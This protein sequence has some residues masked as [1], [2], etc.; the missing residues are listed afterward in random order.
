LSDLLFSLNIVLPIL[1][2][3]LTG[4]AFSRLK[5]A[6]PTFIDAANKLSFNVFLPVLLF[7]SIIISDFQMVFDGKLLVF[8]LISVAVL[9]VLLIITVPLIIR[10][11]RKSAIIQGLFRSNFIIFGVPICRG[12]AGDEGA[13]VAA[14]VSAFL[15]PLYNILMVI[16][17]DYY[18]KDGIKRGAWYYLVRV[19]K[20]PLVIAGLAALLYI[21]VSLLIPFTLPSAVGQYLNY[22]GGL[23]T[24]FALILL[25]AD[26]NGKNAHKNLKTVALVTFLKT[27]AIPFVALAVAV[28]LG[29]QGVQLAV[30]LTVFGAPAA[31]TGY[32]MAKNAKADYL[33]AGE[34]IVGTTLFCILTMFLFIYAGKSLELI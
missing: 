1:L 17:L 30:I 16:V 25:G 11:N 31:V 4:M 34:I 27:A 23:A 10:D 12:I 5:L 32:V 33:L 7:Y 28:V 29:F 18:S 21:G 6:V 19:I 22:I 13:A 8:I 2:L 3:I 9:F 15:V 26:F 14:M 24:P 20:N